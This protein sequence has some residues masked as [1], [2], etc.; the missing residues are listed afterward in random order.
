[1]TIE[2][3]IN[4]Y[5]YQRRLNWMLNSILQQKGEIPEIVTS[6]S[7]AENNG[8]PTTEKV[9]E[10]FRNKGLKIIDVPLSFEDVSNRSISRNKRLKETT[11]EWILFA[12]CDL[13]YDNMFFA[14]L[15]KKLESDKFKNETK[16]IGCDRHSL[17]DKFCIEYFEKDNR[18]Y[19]CIIENITE[20]VEKFP[21]KWLKGA[22]TAPGFNQLANVKSI[23][24]RNQ[25]YS[26][27][28]KDLWRKTR[29]DREFRVRLGG[30]V[31]INEPTDKETGLELKI[32]HL[33]HDRGDCNI[34]R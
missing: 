30:R 33:N 26:G 21:I 31:P 1:M 7:Y 25:V 5:S 22:G 28:K 17:N 15:K 16:V 18:E 19:P 4:C 10:F 6:I 3:V 11:A 24:D 29:S 32:F 13:V 8:N 12:D 34:Q 9:I 14:N 23:R 20:I 2:I 27:G